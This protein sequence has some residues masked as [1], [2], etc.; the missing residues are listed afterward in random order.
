MQKF[1][2]LFAAL[3]LTGVGC[4]NVKTQ[5]VDNGGVYI[6][7]SAGAKWTA[8][9]LLP[10][11]EGVASIDSANVSTVTFDPSDPDTLYLGT[12]GN[13]MLVSYDNA[14]S[15]RQIKEPEV[16]SGAIKSIAV[17]TNDVCTVYVAKG[18][19]VMKTTD[20]LRSFD[21][22]AFVESAGSPVNVVRADWYNDQ[23]VWLG[24]AAGDVVKSIDAGKTWSTLARGKDDIVDVLIS[25]ADSR[26]VYMVTERRSVWRTTDGGANWHVL[27]EELGALGDTGKGHFMTQSADGNVVYYICDYGI[28]RSVDQGTTWEALTLLTKPGSAMVYSMAVSPADA[29]VLYYGTSTTLYSSA[30]GGTNWSTRELPSTRAVTAM[31]VDPN[32]PTTLIAGFATVKE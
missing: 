29:N 18:S 17:D 32:D 2:L 1:I 11:A 30:D 12:T 31:V 16:R 24:T 13:G 19:N 15:W 14:E 10:T 6:T 23:I 20:C 5:T 4:I 25:N 3:A 7:T 9:S 26:V 8:K 22:Q 28:L 21:T 27:D